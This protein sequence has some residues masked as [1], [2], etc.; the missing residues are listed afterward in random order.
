MSNSMHNTH[1][2]YLNLADYRLGTRVLD[3]SDDFFAEMENLV[4]L[5]DPVFIDDKFTQRG[6]WMDG[7]ETRRRRNG[8]HDWCILKLG[9]NG[10]INKINADTT[11]FQGNAPKEISLEVAATDTMPTESDWEEIL[12]RS[13]VKA[14]SHNLFDINSSK[15][16]SKNGNKS[17]KFL[18]LHIYPDGGVARLKIYG[19]GQPNW[20][21]FADGELIDLAAAENGGC[22]VGCSDMF[23]SPKDNLIM[24]GRGVNMGDGWETKRRRGHET[25]GGYD[26]NIV[27]LA[28]K[29]SVKK[30]IID[31][32]HF[33]GN[34]PD[35]FSL[36]GCLYEGK[37][38]IPGNGKGE[39]NSKNDCKWQELITTTPLTADS[40]HIFVKQ[41]ADIESI[42]SHVRLNIYPDGGV[43]RMNVY[44]VPQL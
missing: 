3:A 6:K 40:R 2:E 8:G 23:F 31:T 35:K 24:P 7:W 39:N 26:W 4:N 17:W 30:V 42:F 16:S 5:S 34:Y 29:G 38:R 28:T 19:E 15:N 10:T 11:H 32:A 14:H 12:P 25:D 13:Q 41:I 43:S 20:N 1:T 9:V 44:G 33:K 36:E 22:S 18:R 37:E 21:N 27:K